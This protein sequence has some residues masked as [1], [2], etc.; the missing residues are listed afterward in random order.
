[1]VFSCA[2]CAVCSCQHQDAPYPQGCPTA[3]L[4]EEEIRACVASYTEEELRMSRTAALIEANWYCRLTRVEET[5]MFALEMGHKRIGIAAC[6][7]LRAEA[8]IF[9]G[10]C[11][12]KGLEA[13]GAICKVGSIDKTELGLSEEDKIHPGEFEAMCDPALQAEVLRRAG[14][15]LNVIVGLCVGHDTIFIRHSASP[16][17]YLVVKDRVTCHA[18]AAPLHQT[19]SYYRRLLAPGFP[20]KRS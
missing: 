5:I 12:A 18:P 10:V 1:M 11:E 16:V 3:A 8:R 14:T 9:A 19:G 17:T 20:E 15:E 6:A 2:Q 7:G 13:I 4:S